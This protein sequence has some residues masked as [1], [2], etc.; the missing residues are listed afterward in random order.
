MFRRNVLSSL[1]QLSMIS[2][3]LVISLLPLVTQYFSDPN[4][5]SDDDVTSKI[6]KLRQLRCMQLIPLLFERRMVQ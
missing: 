6:D 4:R 1:D 3:G 5:D 2:T